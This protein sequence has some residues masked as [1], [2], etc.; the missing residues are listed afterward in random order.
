MMLLEYSRVMM[1]ESIMAV[2]GRS[3]ANPR[4]FRAWLESLTIEQLATE[5]E[6]LFE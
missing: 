1:I 2:Y 5:F 3:Q 6:K 4:A